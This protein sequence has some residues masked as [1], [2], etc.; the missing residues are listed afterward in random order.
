MTIHANI[1]KGAVLCLTAA[2]LVSTTA[3]AASGGIRKNR[4]NECAIW[5]CLPGGFGTGCGAAKSAFVGRITDVTRKGRRNFTSL[6][7]FSNCVDQ[8]PYQ[9][10]QRG[11][12]SVMTYSETP[13]AYIPEQKVCAV[14]KV[15]RGN[16][17]DDP[18]FT[19]CGGWKTVPEQYVPGKWCEHASYDPEHDIPDTEYLDDGA[20]W[21]SNKHPAWCTVTKTRIT[22]YG[23]GQEYGHYDYKQ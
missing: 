17:S 20:P 18:D 19:Y 14:R 21:R 3:Q 16:T 7:A 6:P 22:V 8:D 12:A 15:K 11:K 2:M 5:L 1:L 23:D 4:L 13:T 10:G 9:S